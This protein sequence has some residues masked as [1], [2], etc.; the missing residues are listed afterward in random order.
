MKQL[1]LKR[2]L[3]AV[4]VLALAVAGYFFFFTPAEFRAQANPAPACQSSIFDKSALVFDTLLIC[5]TKDV[6]AEKLTHAANVAAEWLDNDGDGIV[7]EPRLIEIFK[8]SRPV[9]VMSSAGISPAAMPRIMTALSGYQIQDLHASETNPGGNQRDASQEEIHHVI[10][11]GGWIP[12]LPATFSDQASQSSKLY[13]AWQL[14]DTN[15]L[16]V[17]NDPTCNDS[18]KVT[19][20]VYLATAAYFGGDIRDLQTEE[21]RLYTRGELQQSIPAVVEIFESADYVY[22]TDHWPTG[23]YAHQQNIQTFG[24]SE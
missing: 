13:Q 7:D 12:L 18:C 2:I 6:P 3:P 24:L 20:F 22:P 8:T 11:N 15:Q 23:D 21:I 16:Y 19:E 9:V 5:G 4:G 10:M 1:I 14:A 17:Y